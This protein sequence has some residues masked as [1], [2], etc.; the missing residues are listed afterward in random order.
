[1]LQNP[2]FANFYIPK[3]TKIHQNS[4]IIPEIPFTRTPKFQ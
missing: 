4:R 1:M 3:S 2:N